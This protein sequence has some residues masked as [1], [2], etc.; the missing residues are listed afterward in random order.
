MVLGRA[1]LLVA[2]GSVVGLPVAL[3]SFRGVAAFLF[4]VRRW[5]PAI[6]AG[7]LTVVAVVG[8]SAALVP[9]GYAA[10]TD[11]WKSLRHD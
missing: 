4:G 2:L 10:R 6:L 3:G 11:A 5:D 8:V 1:C 9:A 7:V